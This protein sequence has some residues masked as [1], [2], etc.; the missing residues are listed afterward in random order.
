[1][2]THALVFVRTFSFTI[3]SWPTNGSLPL[4][5]NQT[6]AGMCL[7]S[8][9]IANGANSPVEGDT[10]EMVACGAKSL[11][12]AFNSATSEIVVRTTVPTG[13]TLC[14]AAPNPPPDPP[15]GRPDHYYSCTAGLAGGKRLEFPFCNSSLDEDTR[16]DDLLA[17]ATCEEKSQSITSSGATIPRLGVPR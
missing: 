2:K 6:P 8:S 12:F 14:L 11:K 13:E 15:P 10:T 4:G 16:L 9:S 1:M 17:R 3:T 5:P 7:T